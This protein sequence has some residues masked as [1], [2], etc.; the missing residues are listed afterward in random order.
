MNYDGCRR[1]FNVPEFVSR[2]PEAAKNAIA[3]GGTPAGKSGKK[4]KSK[5]K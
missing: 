5:G 1:K 2:Y 3:A 4:G